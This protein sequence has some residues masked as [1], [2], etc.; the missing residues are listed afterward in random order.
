[1]LPIELVNKILVYV[2][3]LEQHVIITQYHPITRKEYYQINFNSD[4]LWKIK[5]TLVM[6]RLY[7][8][9]NGDFLNKSNIELYKYGTRHYENQLA[10]G[11]IIYE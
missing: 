4:F 8:I 11:R 5:S 2:G 10:S 7:P 6:K 3:E 9:Y 1:M